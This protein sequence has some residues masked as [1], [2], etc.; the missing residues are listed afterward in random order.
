MFPDQAVFCDII[1]QVFPSLLPEYVDII[2]SYSIPYPIKSHVYCSE[3]FYYSVQFTILFAAVLPVST[4]VGGCGWTF[5]D[6]EVRVD[7]YFW[8]LSNNPPYSD[9]VDDAMTFLTML[10]FTCTGLFSGGVSV[11]SVIV[12]SFGPIKKIH[13]LCCV[14]LFLRCSM[15]LNR[16]ILLYWFFYILSLCLHVTRCNSRI[17]WFVLLFI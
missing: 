6:T 9:S 8:K 13:L 1:C 3:C 10:N 12:I 14:P 4:G 2:L 7:V 16:Y 17:V 5:Y 11:I 15:H